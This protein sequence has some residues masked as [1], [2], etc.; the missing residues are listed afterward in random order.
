MIGGLYLYYSK[1][2]YIKYFSY[3]LPTTL[4]INKL[5]NKSTKTGTKIQKGS[6]SGCLLLFLLR[7]DKSDRITWLIHDYFTL[8]FSFYERF[9]LYP[10]LIL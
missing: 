3:P 2:F 4:K 6:L 9:S 7:L 8:M 1:Q 10:H 5:Q